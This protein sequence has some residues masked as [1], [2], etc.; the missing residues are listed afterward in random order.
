M[1]PGH[2]NWVSDT[3]DCV[4]DMLGAGGPLAPRGELARPVSLSTRAGLRAARVVLEDLPL[5]AELPS[6]PRGHGH[7]A[8]L[9]ALAAPAR[10]GARGPLP[11]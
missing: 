3:I 2:K 8:L 11:P 9:G 4:Y 10:L 5:L 7:R 6:V 1:C